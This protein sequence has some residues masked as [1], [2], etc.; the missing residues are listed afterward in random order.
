M[1]ARRRAAGTVQFLGH[2]HR[3]GLLDDAA[4]FTLLDTLLPQ[5]LSQA[6]GKRQTAS[7]S[8]MMSPVQGHVVRQALP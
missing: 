5:Q 6:D 2:L 7:P 1:Q 4:V 3:E 8:L